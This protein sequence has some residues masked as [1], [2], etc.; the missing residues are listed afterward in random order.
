MRRLPAPFARKTGHAFGDIK[1]GVCADWAST[2]KP[3]N[4]VACRA[5]DRPHPGGIAV[6]AHIR[7][8][9]SRAAS[10]DD[11]ANGFCQSGVVDDVLEQGETRRGLVVNAPHDDHPMLG[12]F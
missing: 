8:D 5:L 9:E 3:T 4:Q 1:S 10:G 2:V 12:K 6:G 11:L 7:F